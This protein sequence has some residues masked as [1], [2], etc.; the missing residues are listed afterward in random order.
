MS[1]CL[2]PAMATDSRYP[3]RANKQLAHAT[4]I[5]VAIHRFRAVHGMERL[6]EKIV[7][8][9]A[10]LTNLDDRELRARASALRPR[11]ARAT[12]NDAATVQALSCAAETARRT[13]GMV[14]TAPMLKSGLALLTGAVIE[15]TES[16]NVTPS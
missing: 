9:S 4:R 15:D 14:M 1:E 2:V 5:G 7:E 11:L 13:L 3:Q 10:T 6:A 12:L 8:Q 16:T